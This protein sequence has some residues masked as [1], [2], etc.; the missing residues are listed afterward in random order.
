[1]DRTGGDV[2]IYN[3][4]ERN[5]TFIGLDL[6]TR[7]NNNFYF[8]NAFYPF[9]AMQQRVIFI[10]CPP[11]LTNLVD[12]QQ[13]YQLFDLYQTGTEQGGILNMFFKD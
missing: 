12:S 3:G 9:T 2:S 7:Y 8:A 5:N 11:F 4:T 10:F 6:A 1:M 13:H